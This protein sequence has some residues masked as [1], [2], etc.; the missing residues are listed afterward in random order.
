MSCDKLILKTRTKIQEQLRLK[1]SLAPDIQ[2]SGKAIALII[3]TVWYLHGDGQV[4]QKGEPET[5]LRI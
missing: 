2:I 5:N 1:Q 3:T 4:A